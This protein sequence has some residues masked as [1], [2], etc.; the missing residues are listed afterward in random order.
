MTSLMWSALPSRR[1]ARDYLEEYNAATM[2]KVQAAIPAAIF[3]LCV[4]RC[5]HS[6]ACLNPPVPGRFV[7]DR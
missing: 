5:S 4:V 3:I 2:A 1:Y 6:F 7:H